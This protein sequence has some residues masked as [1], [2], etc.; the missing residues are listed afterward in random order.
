[1]PTPDFGA[2]RVEGEEQALRGRR[3][4][5]PFRRGSHVD[6][7]DCFIFRGG[8]GNAVDGL[9]VILG[10]F[11]NFNIIYLRNILNF[12][13]ISDVVLAIGGRK[14]GLGRQ[15]RLVQDRGQRGLDHRQRN[16]D[17]DDHLFRRHDRGGDVP[18]QLAGQPG[19]S[20]GTDLQFARRSQL[21]RQ[22]E[23]RV[24]R[25]Q[26]GLNGDQSLTPEGA[27]KRDAEP[28]ALVPRGT[29]LLCDFC[30]N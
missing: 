16:D 19:Q 8:D 1:V 3:A 20:V 4:E 24:G 15:R 6:Q 17:D 28:S 29:R 12:V 26:R 9:D 25:E 11:V 2:V 5:V 7:C 22:R 14:F 21:Q 30:W 23:Q 18:S 13:D 27:V 10:G